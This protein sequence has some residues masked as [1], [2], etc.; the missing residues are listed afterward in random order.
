MIAPGGASEARAR[1]AL[2]VCSRVASSAGEAST[3]EDV[4]RVVT[5]ETS[6]LVG[7]ERC[8]IHLR[9]EPGDVFRG[10]FGE[11]RGAALGRYITRS[12]AG[13]P[14]DGMTR[15]VVETQRPLIVGKARTDPRTV[16]SAMRFWRIESMLAVP[17]V[18]ADD[19]VGIIFLDDENRPHAFSDD[20]AELAAACARAAAAAVMHVRARVEARSQLEAAQRQ[21]SALR[22]ATV[23]DER[24]SDLLLEGGSLEDLLRALAELTAKPC[25]IF[26]PAGERVAT[27]LPPGSHDDEMVPRLLEPEVA[28]QPGVRAA[29]TANQGRRAF[30]VGPVRAAGILHRHL[31]AA[32]RPGGEVW[33]NLVVMEH[34]TRFTAGEIVTLRRA[35]MLLAVHVGMERIAV[36]PG[37]NATSALVAELLGGPVEPAAVD[38]RATRLGIRLDVRRVVMVLGARAPRDGGPV[39][40]GAVDDAFGDAAPELTVRAAR[41]SA[42]T[43][44]LIDLPADADPATFVAENREMFEHVRR[45]VQQPGEHLIAGVS[46][47]HADRDGYRAAHDEARQVIECLRRFGRGYGP[48]LLTADDLGAGRVVL[49]TSDG[50]VVARFAEQTFGPLLTDNAN[51]G[52]LETLCTF[53]RTVGSIRRTAACLGVHENTI[54]YRLARV[55]ELT[56]LAVTRDPDAQLRARLSL[57]VLVL[58]GR[59]PAD[60]LGDESRRAPRLEG[61]RSP[62]S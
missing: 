19:V 22:R 42:D 58:Q 62:S 15:E 6:A 32:I 12:L 24:L 14:A 53:F 7:V 60:G 16:K 47:V 39:D 54:R 40:A 38:R 29:V 61:E 55:E 11:S 37:A 44:A 9:D 25:A 13:G 21:V 5:R 28:R 3:I 59:L 10:C 50:Q 31:V 23:V 33:G 36:E 51:G 56:G 48:A 30:V 52:L 57:L 27:A 34:K 17:M 8:S 4:L 43:A 49:A 35:A 18:W 1:R 41:I 20:D 46:G 45:L 2:D 26:S